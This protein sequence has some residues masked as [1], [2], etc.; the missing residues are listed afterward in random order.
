VRFTVLEGGGTIDG[1]AGPVTR[2]SGTDG[3]ASVAWALD[4][5]T[6]VQRLEAVLLDAGG[7]AVSLPV[8]FSAR[9]RTAD[10]VAY[11]P[12]ACA[13]LAGVTNVQDAIDALCGTRGEDPGFRVKEVL[14]PGDGRELRNDTDVP[15]AALSD[16][17]V[18]L[19]TDVVDPASIEGKPTCFVTLELPYPLVPADQEFWGTG[20]RVAA[21]PLI[22]AGQARADGEAIIWLPGGELLEWLERVLVMVVEFGQPER[23]LMRLTLH[24]D[25]IWSAKDPGLFL[26]GDTFGTPAGSRTDLLRNADGTLSGDGRRGDDFRMWFWLVRERRRPG[27]RPFIDRF[28]LRDNVVAGRG[29][30][31]VI[32]LSEPAP[33]GGLT[34]VLRSSDPASLRLPETVVVEEGGQEA[35]FMVTSTGAL[36]SPTTV[37]VHAEAEGAV[38]ARALRITSRP[39]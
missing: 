8:R 4:P 25:F 29:V 1:A 31:G 20:P 32:T 11:D 26:D 10:V 27:G 22:L 37:S 38:L 16:G 19:C 30:R 2:V 12:A 6:P 5:T 21:Q 24:G 28:D 15:V 14:L 17:I 39:G 34:I 23:V 13:G 33:A 18:V 9:L 3:L 36:G 35:R 7:Q